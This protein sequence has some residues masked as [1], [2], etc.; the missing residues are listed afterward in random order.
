[1]MATASLV[2]VVATKSSMWKTWKSSAGTTVQQLCE[3]IEN[4][5]SASKVQGGSAT[6]SVWFE[7]E[8]GPQRMRTLMLSSHTAVGE[9]DAQSMIRMYSTGQSHMGGGIHNMKGIGS[10]LLLAGMGGSE[11]DAADCLAITVDASQRRGAIARIGPHLDQIYS[12]RDGDMSRVAAEISFALNDANGDVEATINFQQGSGMEAVQAGTLAKHLICQSGHPFDCGDNNGE[13]TR[14]LCEAAMECWAEASA[15]SNMSRTFTRFYFFNLGTHNGDADTPLLALDGDGHVKCN[16]LEPPLDLDLALRESYVPEGTPIYPIAG[17]DDADLTGG[18]K[19]ISVQ[20]VDAFH[21]AAE[22]SWLGETY[23]DKKTIRS[24][25]LIQ[26]DVFSGSKQSTAFMVAMWPDPELNEEAEQN[27]RRLKGSKR[28]HLHEDN[29]KEEGESFFTGSYL[30]YKDKIINPY[31]PKTINVHYPGADS[32]NR[33]LMICHSQSAGAAR[34]HIITDSQGPLREWLGF[35]SWDDYD[36]WASSF[37]ASRNDIRT[38]PR[39]D[40]D[41]FYEMLTCG[42]IFIVRVDGCV[43]LDT[44]KDDLKDLEGAPP[45]RELVY[46]IRRAQFRWCLEHDPQERTAKA[47]EEAKKAAD[48][49]AR[50]AASSGPLQNAGDG[51]TD[52]SAR[53]TRKKRPAAAAAGGGSGGGEGSGGG[54]RDSGRGGGGKKAKKASKAP[55]AS[56]RSS[57]RVPKQAF[58]QPIASALQPFQQHVE[59]L[60]DDEADLKEKAEEAQGDANELHKLIEQLLDERRVIT[61]LWQ[62]QWKMLEQHYHKP[63]AVAGP[64][65]AAAGVAAAAYLAARASSSGATSSS[66][67]PNVVEAQPIEELHGEEDDEQ[68][69]EE[70]DS[71]EAV[72]DEE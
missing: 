21:P 7:E 23:H 45:V 53:P 32:Y 12:G 54:G 42:A 51:N 41:R 43:D 1:M 62:T 26:I 14:H 57:P 58:P 16:D 37:S 19:R 66:V 2:G 35:G 67:A 34:K 40:K 9:A 72:G 60:A 22:R 49:Q 33:M 6:G 28:M 44:R 63:P 69:V 59:Q 25:E 27:L 8:L 47:A 20:G 52:A 71:D 15:E 36:A 64:S 50:R 5:V 3:W 39:F 10:R 13:T 11:F 55:A 46:A 70:L 18:R 38:S 68:E 24:N 48:A 31:T 65:A 56:S 61:T 30:S 17:R 29:S 4:V